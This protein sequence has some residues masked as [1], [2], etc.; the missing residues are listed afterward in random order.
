MMSSDKSI[1]Q[2][3]NT[4]TKILREIYRHNVN[5]RSLTVFNIS[6]SDMT[7]RI[8]CCDTETLYW[9]LVNDDLKC[10]VIESK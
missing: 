9:I 8:T 1:I 4:E 5:L 10:K 6:D 7:Y 2:W 3:Y